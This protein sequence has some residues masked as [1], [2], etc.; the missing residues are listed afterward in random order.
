MGVATN[1]FYRNEKVP[2]F[3][4]PVFLFVPFLRCFI[5]GLYLSD[6]LRS[7]AASALK[8]CEVEISARWVPFSAKC[9]AVLVFCI[10]FPPRGACGFG[11]V[12]AA[13]SCAAQACEW[14]SV[15]PTPLS[16]SQ[17]LPPS[18]HHGGF[19]F[20]QIGKVLH[21]NGSCCLSECGVRTDGVFMRVSS[22]SSCSCPLPPSPPGE[23]ER[24]R[25]IG[26]ITALR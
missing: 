16:P 3:V 7:V 15:I 23:R 18:T 17:H 26:W 2:V 12:Q 22:S 19:Y 5:P 9:H 8:P 24:K 14:G 11:S 4:Q 6:A 25:G 1:L 20:P 21:I 13:A 10:H